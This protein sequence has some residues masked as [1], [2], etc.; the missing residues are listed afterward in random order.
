MEITRRAQVDNFYEDLLSRL[1]P[2]LAA[3]LRDR[4]KK[5]EE[6]FIAAAVAACPTNDGSDWAKPSCKHCHGTGYRGTLVA[7]GEKIACN[8]G[9]KR[10]MKWMKNFREEYNKMRDA[11]GQTQSTE[12]PTEA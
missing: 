10:Y 1:P 8:C 11:N 2:P 9:E 6:D 5:D 4:Y 7:T 3:S 12:E